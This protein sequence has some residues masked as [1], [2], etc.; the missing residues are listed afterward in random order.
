VKLPAIASQLPHMLDLPQ[1][2]KIEG[3]NLKQTLN[4]TL[5]SDKAVIKQVLDLA[6]LRGIRQG[7]AITAQ[8]IHWTFEGTS[9]GGGGTAGQMLNGLSSGRSK[10]PT[11]APTSRAR[12]I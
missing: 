12:S 7:K 4:L 5:S 6:D 3:G 2:V 11:W 10:R 1:D 8:P 9:L